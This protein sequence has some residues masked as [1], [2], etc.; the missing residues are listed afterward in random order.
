[1]CLFLK[2]I[3]YKIINN[4]FF[5]LKSEEKGKNNTFMIKY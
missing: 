3:I 5:F 2:K 4:F 1:M